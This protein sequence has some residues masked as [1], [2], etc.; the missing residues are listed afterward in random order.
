MTTKRALNRP[1]ERLAYRRAEAA[2]TLGVSETKFVDWE[3]RGLMP[4]PVKID[5]VTLYDAQQLALAWAAMREG[6]EPAFDTGN[7]YDAE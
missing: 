7:P 3:Q 5:G 2:A 1:I 6:L 4:K